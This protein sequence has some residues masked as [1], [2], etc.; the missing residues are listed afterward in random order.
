MSS[1]SEAWA[2][3]GMRD[4]YGYCYDTEL[5]KTFWDFCDAFAE[6]K[7]SSK[8]L[9]RWESI[10]KCYNFAN[11]H[12]TFEDELLVLISSDDSPKE[13]SDFSWLF[14]KSTALRLWCLKSKSCYSDSSSFRSSEILVRVFTRLLMSRWSSYRLSICSRRRVDLSARHIH[15]T[16]NRDLSR[17]TFW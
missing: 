11:L 8:T 15:F 16:K 3:C 2:C 13:D 14:C 7:P 5:K 4:C 9:S 6:N 17:G 12:Y 10:L 1:L